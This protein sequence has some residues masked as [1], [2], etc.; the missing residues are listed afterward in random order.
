MGAA[1]ARNE[2][3]GISEENFIYSLFYI[4][5]KEQNNI[6]TQS[7][8]KMWLN[9]FDMNKPKTKSDMESFIEVYELFEISLLNGKTY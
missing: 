9:L 3:R 1:C 2:R 7:I 4:V 8:S 6:L 5:K